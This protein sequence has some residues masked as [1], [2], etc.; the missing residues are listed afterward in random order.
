MYPGPTKAQWDQWYKGKGQGKAPGAHLAQEGA[1]AYGHEPE[2]PWLSMFSLTERTPVSNR[3]TAFENQELDDEDD[4]D[5]SDDGTDEYIMRRLAIPLMDEQEGAKEIG[6]LEFSSSESENDD[7]QPERCDVA[8]GKER[9][10]VA[11]SDAPSH[12]VH[13]ATYRDSRDSHVPQGMTRSECQMVASSDARIR[14]QTERNVYAQ[15]IKI[16]KFE[17]AADFINADQSR[18]MEEEWQTNKMMLPE[19][20]TFLKYHSCSAQQWIAY[21]GDND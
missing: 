20:T 9:Q 18:C 8:R 16:V 15:A 6:D 1:P 19:Q 7:S 11:S 2:A 17:V 14:S 10:M 21:C 4:A 13:A 3:Y 5:S 12:G